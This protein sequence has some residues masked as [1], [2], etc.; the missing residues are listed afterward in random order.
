M[1]VQISHIYA[2]KLDKGIVLA[3]FPATCDD[4]QIQFR[5]YVDDDFILYDGFR[6][7]KSIYKYA[8]L[9]LYLYKAFHSFKLWW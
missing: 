6:N 9:F 3:F 7:L 4:L 8:R 1:L 5:I 2:V